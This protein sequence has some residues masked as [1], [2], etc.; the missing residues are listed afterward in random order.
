[1]V[2]KYHS[3]LHGKLFEEIDRESTRLEY[4]IQESRYLK[5]MIGTFQKDTEASLKG[6][7][8]ARPGISWT[9]KSIK[10][11]MEYNPVNKIRTHKCILMTI[12]TSK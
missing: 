10:T 1:L 6:F 7:S 12:Y 4:L 2:S 11:V 3:L 8:L 5:K 9:F